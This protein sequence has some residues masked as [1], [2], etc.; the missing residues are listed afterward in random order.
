[1]PPLA[2]TTGSPS[3]RSRL[4]AT[5]SPPSAAQISPSAS[6]EASVSSPTTTRAAPRPSACA[7]ARPTTRRRRATAARRAPPPRRR[8][9]PAEAPPRIASRS[10]AYS[11]VTPRRSTYARASASASPDSMGEPATAR[12]GG[13]SRA[14][15][16]A[17][18]RR[19]RPSRSTTPITRMA[20]PW[21]VMARRCEHGDGQHACDADAR[22]RRDG[23]EAWRRRPGA[24]RALRCRAR[25]DRRRRRATVD[26]WWCRAAGRS[27]T[28]SAKWIAGSSSPMMR[29][30]GWRCWPW[31]STRTSSRRGWSAA[32]SSRN[33]A[34]WPRA[35][36]AGHV[37]VLAPSRWLREADPLPHAWTV[38]S[39]SI[40]AWVAGA[41]RRAAPCSR[42]AAGRHGRASWWT[43]TSRARFLLTSRR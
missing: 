21:S 36:S 38:T 4:K 32:Y 29:R 33:R 42:Q 17:R 35:L 7:R 16:H 18:A 6:Y 19:A 24:R 43:P 23:G 1:M 3:R 31:T 22:C 2:A 20:G 8:A 27:P 25:G 5:R 26:C 11:S 34:R 30:T 41:S 14:V 40:A 39:D 13:S 37:P 12:T 15:R 10:A 28:R 9:R